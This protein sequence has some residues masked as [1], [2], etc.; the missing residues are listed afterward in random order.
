MKKRDTKTNILERFLCSGVV[1]EKG[2]FDEHRLKFIN[3]FS[4]FGIMVSIV[5]YPHYMSG[6]YEQWMNYSVIVFVGIL[7]VQLLLRL[8]GSI[9][10]GSRVSF[11]MS[12]LILFYQFYFGGIAVGGMLWLLLL[13]VLAFLFTGK[14]ERFFWIFLVMVLIILPFFYDGFGITYEGLYP[15]A[16]VVQLLGA[17]LVFSVIAGVYAVAVESGLE[18]TKKNEF[19]IIRTSEELGVKLEEISRIK[20]EQEKSFEEIKKKNLILENT[21]KAMLNLIEDARELEGEL[22]KEKSLVEQKVVERTKQLADAKN[23]ISEGWLQQRKEKV[24]LAAS[25]NSLPLGFFLLD[26]Q[27]NILASNDALKKTLDIEREVNYEVLS[28]IFEKCGVDIKLVCNHCRGNLEPLEKSDVSY[29]DKFLR[30]F[31]TSVVES[32]KLVGSVVLV[33]DITEAKLLERAKEEFFTIASHELRTPLTVIR[34]NASMMKEYFG[35]ILGKNKSM[36]EMVG[37]MY[38]AS[39]RLIGIVND[40]LDS[41]RLEQGRMVFKK[42]EF[43]LVKVVDDVIE[44]IEVNARKRK[45]VLKRQEVNVELPQVLADAERTQQVFYN[46]IGNA[47]NY[48]KQGGVIVNIS[49]AGNNLRVRVADTGV[50]IT[51]Q[52]QRLLFRKFQQAGERVL[53]RDVTKGTGLGL[54]I[55]KLLVKGMGGDVILEKSEIGKGSIFAI[56]LPV[57]K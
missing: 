43:D 57:V 21:K 40:F 22:V 16:A 7:I 36:S 6:V 42:E 44:N 50:G 34:G 3:A 4:L 35:E 41:S 53:A 12:V 13:P 20:N 32:G 19:E 46:I 49:Q 8:S 29:H 27:H 25:I 23:K 45:I 18:R 30:F 14:K 11:L 15:T 52:N 56:I 28:E 39:V 55:S 31:F 26:S 38:S 9:E 2:S 47:V 10:L 17:M 37:D 24:W 33:E 1:V 5:F 54:Y 51:P 48:T